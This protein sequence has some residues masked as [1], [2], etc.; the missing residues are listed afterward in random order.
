MVNQRQFIELQLKI[1]F[2][3]G[4]FLL[5][6]FEFTNLDIFISNFFYDGAHQKFIYKDQNFFTVVLHHGV[7]NL[8]YILGCLSIAIGFFA[9]RKPSSKF[10]LRHFLVGALG[11]ILIPTLIALL[12]HLTNKHCPWSLEIYGGNIPYAGLIEILPAGYPAGQCFPAGHAAGGFMWF[13]WA[14]SLWFI[15]PRVGKL[16]LLLG[17]ILGLFMGLT[18]MMQGAHFLSHVLWSAWFSW[19]IA[20]VLALA[21]KVIRLRDKS[22]V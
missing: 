9:Y 3:S 10:K 5:L 2:F 4:I 18:R 22:I 7:K 21:A 16:I 6:I 12:K 19:G 11:L 8:M 17:I 15:Y 14:A 20:L 13:A 1:L